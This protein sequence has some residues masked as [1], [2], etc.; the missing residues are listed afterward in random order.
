ML[1]E[2]VMF[3]NGHG[4]SIGSIP[5]CAGCHGVVTNI[6]VSVDSQ[7]SQLSITIS[8]SHSC[9]SLHAL[10]LFVAANQYRNCTFGGN[11]PMKIKWWPNT[12]GE[13]S[14]VSGVPLHS[15]VQINNF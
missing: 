13:I 7:R 2:N 10:G 8:I 5:D 11:A 4:A 15:V 6:T 12:T 9:D 1:V 14:N 3:K